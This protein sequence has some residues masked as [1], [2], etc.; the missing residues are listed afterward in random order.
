MKINISALDNELRAK[1]GEVAEQLGFTMDVNGYAIEAQK[2]DEFTVKFDGKKF[3]IVYDA[4]NRFF[5]GLLIVA[6]SGAR[7][8]FSV[9]EECVAEELG[10][11]L[12]C[13]RNAV[14]N[15]NHLKQII[16]IIKQK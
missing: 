13:S 15:L 7:K 9:K 14:R 10:I 12:D 4:V 5:R 11:M 16:Q 1:V 8:D 6:K 3:T 2:G